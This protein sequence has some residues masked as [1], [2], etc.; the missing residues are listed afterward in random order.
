LARLRRLH[1]GARVLAEGLT[2]TG[3]AT[4]LLYLIG[5]HT[6]G[7]P[8]QLRDALPLD[9]LPRHATSSVILRCGVWW[10]AATAVLVL[11][12]RTVSATRP[13]AFAVATLGCNLAA[14]TVSLA[15]VRQTG[16]A[17]ALTSSAQLPTLFLEAMV[18]AVAARSAKGVFADA[19]APTEP[20]PVRHRAGGGDRRLQL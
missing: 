2:T 1:D 5:P 19:S 8:L 9:E 10:T 16:L 17:D 6:A 18:V 13:L 3:A 20:T 14:T 12:S 4:G 15:V 7:W 11:N